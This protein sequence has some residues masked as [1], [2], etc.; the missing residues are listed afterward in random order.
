[1]TGLL[2]LSQAHADWR[3][4]SSWLR[5][6]PLHAVPTRLPGRASWKVLLLQA[7]FAQHG[8]ARSAEGGVSFYAP[9]PAYDL[10]AFVPLEVRP[11]PG[12]G[13]GWPGCACERW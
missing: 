1:M 2:G 8:V 11:G 5:A 10:D 12:A 3:A 13:M 7:V 4:S 6:A 9:A